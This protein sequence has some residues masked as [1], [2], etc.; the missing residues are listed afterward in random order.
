MDMWLEV[1]TYELLPLFNN[2][3]YCNT[4]LNKSFLRQYRYSGRW[5]ELSGGNNV[6]VSFSAN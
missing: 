3:G 6:E 2:I 5:Y 1:N 4:K